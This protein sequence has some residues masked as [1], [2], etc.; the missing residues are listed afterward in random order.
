MAAGYDGS[1]RIDTRVDTTGFQRGI[2]ALPKQLSGLTRAAGALGAALTA[3]FAVDKIVAMGK[4]AINLASDLQEVENVVTTAFGDMTYMV[5]DFADTAIE[6]FGMSELAAKRTASTYMAMSKGMGITGK[7]AA[8]MSIA[9]AGLSGDVASFFNVSQDVADTALKSIWTGETETLK[10]FGVVMTQA[11][12]QQFAYQQGIKKKIAAMSQAEQVQLRYMYV[13][14]QLSLAQGDFA[15]TSSSW[16]NQTRILSENWKELL[17]I[18]GNG[19]IEVLLPVVQFLNVLVKG[20]IMVAKGIGAVYRMLTG[21]EM[22]TQ[23]DKVSDSLGNLSDSAADAAENQYGLADGI[24]AAGAAAKNALANF[25]DLDVLQRDLGNNGGGGGGGSFDVPSFSFDAVDFGETKKN[26]KDFTDDIKD[27]LIGWRDDLQED[28]VIQ[29]VIEEP[30]FPLLPSPVW[31]P[32]WGLVPALEVEFAL[33]NQMLGDFQTEMVEGLSVGFEKAQKVYDTAVAN[34]AAAFANAKQNFVTT[35]DTVIEN[36]GIWVTETSRK[37]QTWK[38]NV[39]TAVYDTARNTIDNWNTAL[40]TTAGNAANWI[41]NTSK[42]FV[43]WGEGILKTSWNTAK[44][45]ADNMI[46]GFKTVWENFKSLMSSIGEKVSGAW[47]ENKSWLAPTLAVGAAVAVG[48]GIILS[49]GSLAPALGAAAFLAN[50]AVIPP[51]QEFLAVL[52]DQKSGRNLEAPEGL[53]R[54][55]MREELAGLMGGSEVNVN[56]EFS[57]SLA[58]L[59]RVLHPA[60]TKEQKRIGGTLQTG[61]VL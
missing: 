14:Q 23:T 5:E 4:E 18:L 51:N 38:Q 17:G 45:F 33:A 32:N 13:M 15:R 56:I 31:E 49:G 37:F 34:T 27:I 28:F 41:N 24:N 8:E 7:A 61:G 58:Q 35:K 47:E 12:L 44:G 16:A 29:P 42:N 43:T 54:Q 21:K 10:Q 26:V 39:T 3:A 2:N 60:I 40:E 50:G 20:L 55:I 59:A 6:K 57:G 52:G 11:N 46:N 1:I 25:D 9:V 48:A 22:T 53:I 36:A 19:L 30:E